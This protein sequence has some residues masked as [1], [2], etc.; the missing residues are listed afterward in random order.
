M[1]GIRPAS[2][3]LSRYSAPIRHPQ[4]PKMTFCNGA[5]AFDYSRQD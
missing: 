4:L 2:P 3:E 5:K 1:T